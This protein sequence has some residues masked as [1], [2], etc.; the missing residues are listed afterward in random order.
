M[1]LKMPTV[2]RPKNK[3]YYQFCILKIFIIEAQLYKMG[4]QTLVHI[5]TFFINM[6]LESLPNKV[7]NH[8]DR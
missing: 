8:A 4:D 5:K 6:N 2:L 3:S 7:T 1:T